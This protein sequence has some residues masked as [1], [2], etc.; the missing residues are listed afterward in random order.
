MTGQSETAHTGR[1]RQVEAANT[2]AAILTAAEGRIR[3]QG[4]HATRLSDLTADAGLTTG[5]FYRHFPSKD[6]LYASMYSRLVERL[7]A[8]LHAAADLTQAFEAWLGVCREH[9]GTVRAQFEVIAFGA[10]LADKWSLARDRWEAA[11]IKLLPSRSSDDRLI[12]A[13]V[14]DTMEYYAYAREVSWWGPHGDGEV[15][16][17]LATIVEDGL[18]PP[19]PEGRVVVPDAFTPTHYQTSVQWTPSAGKSLPASS[20]ARR[21]VTSLQQAAVEVFTDLGVRQA[22]MLDI[23]QAAGVASGTAYR[24]FDDK[25]DLLRSLMAQFEQDLVGSALHGLKDQ[26]HAVGDTYR[27]FLALHRQQVG[28]FRAWWALME[29]GSDYESAWVRMHNH[30]M[31][32]FRRVLEHGRR[33]G[34]IAADL[35]LEI[36][37]CLYS[38]IHERSAFAR[39]ALGRDQGADD[40]EVAAVLDRLFNGGIRQGMPRD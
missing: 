17:T 6:A 14:V 20:R 5:A 21:T 10:P 31:A 18:Y 13:L 37:A 12:A 28:I 2:K 3:E 27:T 24:Y 39:V 23:A 9:P 26:R 35:D 16:R 8:A 22:T 25:E 11:L 33:H 4:F 29:P 7:E 38:G 1:R 34:L 36:T 15:A 40:E 30:L 19:W 32:Q